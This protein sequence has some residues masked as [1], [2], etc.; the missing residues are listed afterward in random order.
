MA[1]VVDKSSP[2]PYYQQLAELLRAEIQENQ[3]EH[4]LYQLASENELA[5]LHGLTRATVRH[6]LDVLEREALIYR[7]KGKGSFAAARRVEQD[8]T[9][10]VSTTEAMRQR[11]WSMITRVLS[12]EKIPASVHVAHALELDP[13]TAVYELRRLRIVDESPL[14]VQAAY[15]S[16]TLCPQLEENDLGGSLYRLLEGRYGL[17]LWTG[18]ETLRARGATGLE[19]R[20]LQ[21]RKG[22]P[23][24]YAER[25][26]YSSMGEAVE[27]LEAV[28][29]G[30][31]YDFMVTLQRPTD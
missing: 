7:E 1:L 26:T 4:G 17:R 18:Q 22:A 11:G 15:L 10:L 24:M 5:S 13:Q 3:P 2:V 8:L 29:R 19:A 14:S 6:A 20:L 25:I 12:L 23:V 31:R 30:D 16:E 27:Y 9:Q 28:W 21:V